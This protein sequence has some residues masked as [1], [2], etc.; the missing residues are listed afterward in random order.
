MR[1]ER[2]SFEIIENYNLFDDFPEFYLARIKGEYYVFWQVAGSDGL[3][4]CIPLAIQEYT[5]FK[6]SNVREWFWKQFHQQNVYYIDD[7]TR[8]LRY[9]SWPL[10]SVEIVEAYIPRY[11]F[12]ITRKGIL[13][14]ETA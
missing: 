6:T 9:I 14:V 2:G 11:N 12:Y 10:A 5:K 4:L 13:I 1:L 8:H 3:S 7:L